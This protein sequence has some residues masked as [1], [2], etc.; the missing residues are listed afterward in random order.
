M[1]IAT[2]DWH[3]AAHMSFAS[4]HEGCS[5]GDVIELAGH[6]QVLWPDHCVQQ[7]AGASLHSGLDVASIDIVVR[8]GVDTEIDSYSGFFDNG[9]LRDTG[10][11]AAVGASGHR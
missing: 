4:N 1:V 3:P 7:T 2:Q 11:H 8:K 9:H 6:R 10:M 5:P